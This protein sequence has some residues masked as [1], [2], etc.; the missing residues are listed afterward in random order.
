M[1][2]NL[3]LKVE[4]VELLNGTELFKVDPYGLVSVL[5]G[6]DIDRERTER[7]VIKA[8]LKVNKSS[9]HPKSFEL[10]QIATAE[11]LIDDVNDHSPKFTQKV[12]RFRIDPFP[13]NNTEVGSL[14]AVDG[15]AEEFG[16]LRYRILDEF[17]PDGH[18]GEE[19][20]PFVLF[21][22]FFIA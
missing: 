7:I 11:I 9:L 6:V 12:Y 2:L 18:G 13:Y 8:K 5:P 3:F 15:D 1:D 19:P 4:G 17:V 20:L 22:V 10:C 16:H 21:Q 14:R